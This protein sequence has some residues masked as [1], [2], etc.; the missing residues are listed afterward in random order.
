MTTTPQD[1]ETPESV[2][3]N[4]LKSLHCLYIDVEEV[5]ARD[6]NE[7]VG[8]Y[9]NQLERRAIAAE[10]EVEQAHKELKDIPIGNEHETYSLARRCEIAIHAKQFAWTDMDKVRAE[11][12]SLRTRVEQLEREI[13]EL[14]E[15]YE[16][17]K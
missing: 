5:V 15:K 9:L 12:N 7:K 4:A 6:V 11:R 2:K 16:S 13:K 8:A 3:S 1:S 14:K 17:N 10:K